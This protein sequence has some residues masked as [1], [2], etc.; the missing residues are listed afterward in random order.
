VVCHALGPRRPLFRRSQSHAGAVLI[1]RL[2]RHPPNATA[3][4]IIEKTWSG[5]R[6]SRAT[7]RTGK[8]NAALPA[9]TGRTSAKMAATNKCLAQNNKSRTRGKATKKR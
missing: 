8:S 6:L 1:S 4:R 2:L 7:S 9:R 3:P 5:G